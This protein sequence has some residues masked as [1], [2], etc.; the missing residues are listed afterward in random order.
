MGVL[1]PP[2]FLEFEIYMYMNILNEALNGE[3]SKNWDIFLWNEEDS[4]RMERI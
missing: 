3:A 1:N 4:Y 2:H